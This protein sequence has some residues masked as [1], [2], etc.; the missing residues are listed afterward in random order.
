MALTLLLLLHVANSANIEVSNNWIH[1]AMDPL[2]LSHHFGVQ[3]SHQVDPLMYQVINIK[4]EEGK[5]KRSGNS[6]HH[7]VTFE[8]FGISRKLDMKLNKKLLSKS[9]KFF[10]V[11]G[12][13]KTEISMPANTNCH[14]LHNSEEMSAALSN[15]D[16]MYTGHLLHKE[17]IF[18]IKP[19]NQKYHEMLGELHQEDSLLHVITRKPIS[20]LPDFDEHLTAPDLSQMETEKSK[21]SNGKSKRGSSDLTIETAVFMDPQAF[22]NY[23]QFYREENKVQNMILAFMNGVQSIYHFKSLGRVIDFVLVHVEMQSGWTFSNNAEREKYLNNFCQYQA[24][25]NDKGSHWDIALDMS[26]LDFYAGASGSQVTMGLAPVTGICDKTFNCVIGEVGVN[27]PN[28]KP[29]PSA[30][31]TSVFVMAHEIGHNLG[32]H[33][34]GSSGCASNGFVMSASRGTKGEVE[35]SSC[36]R[37]VV[38]SLAMD[39]LTDGQGNGKPEFD[40]YRKYHNMP[41]LQW[42]SDKQCQFLIRDNEAKTD[43]KEND[44]HTICTQLYCRSPSKKGWFRAGP[45]LEGTRCGSSPEKVCIEGKCQAKPSNIPSTSDAKPKWSSWSRFGKCISGCITSSVGVEKRTRTCIYPDQAPAATVGGCYG[46]GI[47]VRACGN[48]QSCSALTSADAYASDQCQIYMDTNTRLG[49]SL[50][51]E[52]RQ[53]PHIDSKPEHACTIFCAQVRSSEWFSPQPYFTEA[54]GI[55]LY[56]PDGT[57][58]HNDG[59]QNYY[60]LKHQCIPADQSRTPRSDVQTPVDI[61]QNALPEDDSVDQDVLDYFTADDS[62]TPKG[63]PPAGDKDSDIDDEFDQSGDEIKISKRDRYSDRYDDRFYE[64]D[65]QYDQPELDM[66]WRLDFE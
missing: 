16:N 48:H 2:E 45:A 42:S 10:M 50:M 21:R 60:C 12:N 51:A 31:F 37:N 43:H 4:T 1:H 11:N 36:S 18:E 24:G 23:I 13:N 19:L 30:G 29:Y 55:N 22:R 15:C 63:P 28:G 61:F 38:R 46:R 65:I 9:T 44:L 35:W 56:F 5:S 39:C 27:K 3:S 47:E 64:D 32:M 57:K 58:C 40:H 41:G 62:G 17:S 59:R 53:Q 33:H 20:E 34:D 52:G 14:F 8:A 66:D 6:N 25:L 7:S 54:D 49:L 26:G